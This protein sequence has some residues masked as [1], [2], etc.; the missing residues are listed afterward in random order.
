VADV[1]SSKRL[2]WLARK[3]WEL[4]VWSGAIGLLTAGAAYA[5]RWNPFGGR[6]EFGEVM[7]VVAGLYCLVVCI[8]SIEYE[9]VARSLAQRTAESPPPE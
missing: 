3:L 8:R 4:K 1:D 6:P 5:P 9:R 2:D 7:L